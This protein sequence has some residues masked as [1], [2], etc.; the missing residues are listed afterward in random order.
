[1]MQSAKSLNM[2]NFPGGAECGVREISM[3][4]LG[5]GIGIIC[6]GHGLFKNLNDRMARA[7]L[8]HELGHIKD[9]ICKEKD[10]GPIDRQLLLGLVSARE[11]EKEADWLALGVTLDPDAFIDVMNY[12][13]KE[14]IAS[15]VDGKG[16]SDGIHPP[17]AERIATA[18]EMRG[19]L[20]KDSRIVASLCVQHANNCTSMF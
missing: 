17:Y 3:R 20:S 6:I 5:S 2:A 16:D 13:R 9:Y 10:R 1:M 8:A 19:M 18:E 4:W 15:G 11:M 12:A 7:M 14:G